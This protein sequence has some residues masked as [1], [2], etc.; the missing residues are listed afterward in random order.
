MYLQSD[1]PDVGS[2]FSALVRVSGLKSEGLSAH[3]RSATRELVM[4]S[5][6]WQRG[7]IKTSLYRAS[8][9]AQWLKKKK[10][11]KAPLPMQ[12]T[13]VQSLIREDPHFSCRGATKPM[14]HNYWTCALEP[15]RH[16]YWSPHAPWSPCSATREATAMRSPCT[17]TTE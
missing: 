6:T 2:L 1:V 7:G 17:T 14:H 15:R 9:V 12:A 4:A 10:K 3:N 16:D 8:L 13:W 5:P 11:K